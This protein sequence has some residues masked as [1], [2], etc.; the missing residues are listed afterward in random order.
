MMILIRKLSNSDTEFLRKKSLLYQR[1]LGFFPPCLSTR[2]ALKLKHMGFFSD[3]ETPQHCVFLQSTSEKPLMHVNFW[4]NLQAK[5]SPPGL[6][7][8]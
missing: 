8:I 1:N 3:M 2:D 6:M 4:C 7:G 5:A